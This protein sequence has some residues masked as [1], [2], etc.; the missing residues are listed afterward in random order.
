[1][2]KGRGEGGKVVGE[3]GGEQSLWRLG[4]VVVLKPT[5]VKRLALL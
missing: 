4:G 3:G 2:K 5:T 1:M